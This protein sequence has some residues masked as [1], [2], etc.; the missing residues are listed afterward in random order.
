MRVFFFSSR[1]R[2]TRFDCDW[3][4]DVCSSDLAAFDTAYGEIGAGGCSSCF[5]R[6][7]RSPYTDDDDPYTT[8]ATRPR[9]AASST[10]SVPV[11]LFSLAPSG[12]FTE[13]GTDRIAAWWKMTRTPRAAGTEEH[14]PEL[15]PQ[16]N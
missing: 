16:S 3:S 10:L 4:S 8:R 7:G 12:S 15:Q 5:G 6:S 11:T 2:H 9:R 13:R 1:R 14:T